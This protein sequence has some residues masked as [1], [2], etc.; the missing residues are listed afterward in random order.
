M[1]NQEQLE[2]LKQGVDVWNKWRKDNPEVEIELREANLSGVVFNLADLWGAILSEAKLIGAVLSGAKLIGAILRG[3]AK[4]NG[5]DLSEAVLIGANLEQADFVDVKIYGISAWDL[6]LK[7]TKQDNLV[8]TPFDKSEITV[9]NLE[10]AQFIYLLINNEKIR[11]VITT[12]TSS[13]VLIL[14]RFTDERKKILNSIK[15]KCREMKLVSILFDFDPS[16][17]RD[18]TETVQLLANLSR[19]VIA[20]VT[21]AK[22]IPQELSHIIPT[23][24]SVPVQPI[25]LASQREYAMF[26]HRQGFNSVLP[27]FEYSDEEHLLESISKSIMAPVENWNKEKNKTKIL[28]EEN[29]EL[30]RQITEMKRKSTDTK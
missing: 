20:D 11:D 9:D 18:L 17:N 2:I 22:S 25:L 24:P 13:T 27:V 4:L 5:A 10:I 7:D 8:I 30:K 15:D 21:D 19:F 6:N 28:E 23:F 3:A 1:A 12:L 16:P 14:G 26:E 29:A